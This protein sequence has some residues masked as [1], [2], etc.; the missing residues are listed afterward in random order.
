VHNAQWCG[1]RDARLRVWVE[2]KA[3][4][5]GKRDARL[6]VWVEIKVC[7]PESPQVRRKDPRSNRH[8]DVAGECRA[9]AEELS[10][11]VAAVAVGREAPRRG[12]PP[13]VGLGLAAASGPEGGGPEPC[14]CP[15]GLTAFHGG[16]GGELAE[17]FTVRE[18]LA[19]G[20]DLA[21]AAGLDR[22]GERVVESAVRLAVAGVEESWGQLGP[23]S[24]V[25]Q[26]RPVQLLGAL[27]EDRLARGG[28]VRDGCLGSPRSSWSDPLPVNTQA[29]QDRVARL[30]QLRRRRDRPER[31]RRRPW[32]TAVIHRGG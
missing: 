8:L 7:I 9:V 20:E 16:V 14:H 29:D 31:H 5:C 12:R 6:R 13:V 28:G 2:I 22:V 17:S 15:R 11:Q 19:S 4:R 23:V 25:R 10:D 32:N 3:K 18:D 27:E 30:G 26:S 24:P 1:K 21:A